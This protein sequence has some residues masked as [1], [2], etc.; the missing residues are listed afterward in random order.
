MKK[1]LELCRSAM[2]AV[3]SSVLPAVLAMA[4]VAAGCTAIGFGIGA[5]ID[6]SHKSPDTVEGWQILR[7][8]KGTRV[9]VFLR[10]GSEVQ[11]TF[12]GV[13]FDAKEYAQRY[14]EYQRQADG[15]ALPPLGDTIA[16]SNP[17]GKT[18]AGRFE[19]FEFASM[20]L[21]PEGNASPVDVPFDKVSAVSF[22]GREPLTGG[23]L[24]ALSGR[25]ALPQRNRMA[26]GGDLIPIELV[27]RV[28]VPHRGHAKIIGALIGLA[29][30]AVV[31][32]A[33]VDALN[34]PFVKTSCPYVSSFDGH[35]Y[36][37]E[38]EVLAGAMFH[39]SQRSD[40]L[41]LAHLAESQGMYRLR[42]TNELQETQYVDEVKLIV[43][44]GPEDAWVVPGPEGR[45]HGLRSRLAPVEATDLRGSNVVRL[46]T[47]RDGWAW[48]SSPFGRNG[49]SPEDRR[50][51][52]IL[53]FPRPPGASSVRL[54]FAAETTPWASILLRRVLAAQ[55]PQLAAWTERMN[56]DSGARA[57]FLEALRR[58]GQLI[59]SVWT[60]ASWQEV[61]IVTS[62]QSVDLNLAGIPGERLKVR[63]ES[64]V[65]L[66]SVDRV[67][68][69]FGADAPLEA[70]ELS[71]LSAKTREG[72]DVLALVTMRDDR[73]YV[74]K[75]TEGSVDIAFLAPPRKPGRRR[76]V[77]L[78]AAGY[79]NIEIPPGQER[80][81]ALFDRLVSEPGAFGHYSLQ[82]LR[83]DLGSSML[84]NLHRSSSG[85][86]WD[87]GE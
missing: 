46:V 53:G 77:I 35:R 58:E 1:T 2:T 70:V 57:R 74:M 72:K 78:K 9:T 60:G 54:T 76:T 73:H 71:P 3:P 40:R 16:V 15:V 14:E 80:Q 79:Y 21:R 22:A 56:A 64:S 86:R 87:P 28:E 41:V 59:L 34:H 23:Q 18:K 82:L 10:D 48:V 13:S 50:D 6:N 42:L 4:L 30:D 37:P 39:A 69:D 75:P 31:I 83:A 62:H 63:V 65:G 66:W 7:I 20:S 38:G 84:A 67:E 17:K 68:A 19:G 45:L 5:A 55:G 27:N 24:Q 49:E 36:E 47:S 44:D 29:V 32:V 51:G 33:T 81:E 12:S 43:V 11:G 52:L 8:E 85:S 25:G 26:V 61:G